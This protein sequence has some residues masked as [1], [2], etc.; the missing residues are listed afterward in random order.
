M[1]ASYM[2]VP[3]GDLSPL[4]PS[5]LYTLLLSLDLSTKAKKKK[6]ASYSLLF[7]STNKTRP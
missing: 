2:L 1:A 6:N 7:W 4:T 5:L 3:V